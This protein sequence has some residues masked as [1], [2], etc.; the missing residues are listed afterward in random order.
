M[1][2]IFKNELN[3]NLL[4]VGDKIKL[5][6]VNHIKRGLK[7]DEIEPMKSY[8]NNGLLT[9]KELRYATE[10]NYKDYKNE[11]TIQVE[12]MPFW[13]GQDEVELVARD[14][15]MIGDKVGLNIRNLSLDKITMDN[16][17]WSVGQILHRTSVVD[18]PI[19]SLKDYSIPNP[20][21]KYEVTGFANK[22]IM[23]LAQ[24]NNN[25]NLIYEVIILDRATSEYYLVKPSVI[26]TINF[27]YSG[28]RINKVLKN[29]E[30]DCL[31]DLGIDRLKLI[32]QIDTSEEGHKDNLLEL[33]FAIYIY[34]TIKPIIWDYEREKHPIIDPKDKEKEEKYHKSISDFDEILAG[35][36]SYF[37]IFEIRDN[38]SKTDEKLLELKKRWANAKELFAKKVGTL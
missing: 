30:S 12:E 22:P 11:W 35:V 3:T 36:A 33:D 29:D 5:N 17:G 20:N 6:K 16:L 21:T 26:N 4:K 25:K 1:S 24:D 7:E 19:H 8:I 2:K 32:K 13:L 14:G 38:V 18:A 31:K 28:S 10:D 23:G 27:R 9:V 15:L 34:D 37:C